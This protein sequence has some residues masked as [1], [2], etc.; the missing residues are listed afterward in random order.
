MSRSVEVAVH[1]TVG[2]D[3]HFYFL[4]YGK[5]HQGSIT[6]GFGIQNTASRGKIHTN[7]KRNWQCAVEN[8]K[9]KVINNFLY[10]QCPLDGVQVA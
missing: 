8:K 9:G 6:Q 10:L 4:N 2:K 1:L 5:F 3:P 7:A